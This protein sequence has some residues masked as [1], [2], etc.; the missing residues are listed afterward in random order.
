M[1]IFMLVVLLCILMLP[2]IIRKVEDHLEIFLFVAG[3]FSVAVSGKISLH[4][5]S[6]V[7]GNIFLYM[8]TFAV[9]IGGFLFRATNKY[10]LQFMDFV[11]THIPLRVFIFALI[12]VIGLISSFITAII[13]SLLLVELIEMLPI[14]RSN[15]IKITVI[16]CFSIGFGAILTPIGEPLSTVVATKLNLNFWYF[17]TNLGVY[18]IPPIF[19]FGL[20]GAFYGKK[21]NLASDELKFKIES[22]SSIDIILRAVKIFAFIIA[23]DMLGVSFK[24]LVETYI[25]KLDTRILYWINTISAV[26]DN[27][28]LAAAEITPKMSD[29]QIKSVLL[30][31]IISGGM[32]IPGNIPNIISAGKLKIKS[33]EWLKFGIPL[34]L[35]TMVTYYIILFVF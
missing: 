17:L 8:I 33:S 13:A 5:I 11:L 4:F 1:T 7:F 25:V 29:M 34:G 21:S 10:I 9:L 14:S 23:L 18:I 26:L 32:L 20:L 28:T 27:A 24:P 22:Q 2:L 3:L 31:L 35:F 16:S 15:K 12:T 19:A 30:G 6:E